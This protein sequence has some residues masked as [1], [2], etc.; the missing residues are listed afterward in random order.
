VD[1]VNLDLTFVN[2]YFPDSLLP[3]PSRN[4]DIS[5]FRLRLP[6]FPLGREFEWAE[7]RLPKD[8]PDYNYAKIVLSPDAVLRI[9][10][11]DRNGVL[12]NES[13]DPGPSSGFSPEERIC[14]LLQGYFEQ[15]L[16]PWLKGSLDGDFEAETL[17][18]WAIEVDHAYSRNNPV[19]IVWIV[20]SCPAKAI[21]RQGLLLIPGRIAIASD[22][23]LPITNRL[24]QSM[25]KDAS[26]RIRLLVADIPI[27]H[28]LVP[29]TW[30]RNMVD[31]DRILS[32]RLAP[33]DYGKFCSAT[34]RRGHGIH[35]I[36]L[37]RNSESAFAYLLPGGSSIIVDEGNCGKTY[38]SPNQL[39]PLKA[40]RLDP[41]WTAGRDQH[42]EI[43]DRQGKYV[44]VSGVGALGSPVI[45][46]LAKAGV[47]HI[48]IVDADDLSSA[49][50]GRHLLGAESIGR[51]KA[52]V[53]AQR[54]NFAHPATIVTPF[55]MTAERYLKEH[56]LYGV[57]A[58]LDLTGEPDVR[59]YVDRARREHSRPLL[60]GWMEPFVAA[61]HVCLLPSKMFWIKDNAD[62][63]IDLEAVT[64]PDEII[65]REPGCSSRF[66][67]YTAAAAAHAVALIAENA[68]EMID[69]ADDSVT[70]RVVSWV[71][72]QHFLD[73]HWPGLFHRDWAR[74]AAQHDGLIIT[75][76]FP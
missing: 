8:F 36:V 71:R 3:A 37:L 33:A 35:K 12:C 70:A 16:K 51:S 48:T 2:Q 23:Q 25:G 39:L 32:G 15:F 54:V 43:E 60:I 20:D 47:G 24:I 65:R 75:R 67:S 9:P 7:L 5:T 18:Y 46:H 44:L 28:T 1:R 52:K 69:S 66:Q 6:S 56:S 22:D 72:G 64:W 68:L 74:P 4:Y 13:G 27:P 26:Q 40:I 10:H 42:P 19:Q 57:D 76:P 62:M 61:A 30:P 11:L 34:G 21:I 49:N 50:I 38:P 29:N 17:N 31:L 45:D 63:L 53:V 58:I 41:S 59:W 55:E 14:S 73:R